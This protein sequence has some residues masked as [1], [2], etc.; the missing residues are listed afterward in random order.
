MSTLTAQIRMDM[1]VRETFDD[2]DGLPTNSVLTFN[3]FNKS[4]NLNATSTPP[5]TKR[6]V[7]TKA[8]TAGAATIDLT[9]IPDDIKTAV[10]GTGLKVIGLM[11]A[12]PSTNTNILIVSQGAS[13]GYQLN[14]ENWSLALKPGEA[15]I[16]Y[17]SN[18]A[19]MPDVDATHKNIDLSDD[20]AGGTDTHQ[21]VIL[22]G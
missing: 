4:A 15:A 11:I 3:A 1:T 10:D 21:F 20:S 6:G 12:N 13:N 17:F 7:F 9:A 22:L 2:V 16:M 8:L 18:A 5:V 19:T 14:G